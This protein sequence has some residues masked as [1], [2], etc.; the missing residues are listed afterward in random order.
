MSAP[1]FRRASPVAAC[2]AAL[3][4]AAGCADRADAPAVAP[5][6]GDAPLAASGPNDAAPFE[7]SV[8]ALD[9]P[10]RIGDVVAGTRF[11]PA[12]DAGWVESD[13]HPETD[14]GYFSAGPLPPGISMMV[15]DG[16]VQ[17]FEL[18]DP[19]LPLAG[20][21]G[22]RPGMS[23]AAALA[24]MP[25]GT[26]STPHEYGDAGDVYLTWRDAQ[27]GIGVRAEVVG[28]TVEA[29]FWGDAEAIQL[30]ESCS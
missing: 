22:L 8:L 23:Q 25:A 19:D 10:G 13:K 1:G 17:R 3:C 29:V 18:Y 2:V 9:A 12:P 26:A 21:F 20:P 4:L 11:E 6:S 27:R 7:G 28:E 24:A 30:A 16:R 15:A 14:C 5:G